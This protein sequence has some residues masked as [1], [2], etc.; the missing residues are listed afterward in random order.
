MALLVLTLN[1]LLA[2]REY[3]NATTVVLTI[4]S[5]VVAAAIAI[6]LTAQFVV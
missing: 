6:I 2:L 3:I 4:Q 1:A 5:K